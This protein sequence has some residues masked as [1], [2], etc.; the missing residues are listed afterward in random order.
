[1][2][3][4]R[5]GQLFFLSLLALYFTWPTAVASLRKAKMCYQFVLPRI[6][7]THRAG[8]QPAPYVAI[9]TSGDFEKVLKCQLKEPLVPGGLI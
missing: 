8:D 9:G 2:G 3:G 7:R 6:K 4:A 5:R 1:M